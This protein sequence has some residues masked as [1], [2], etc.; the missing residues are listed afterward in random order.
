MV[1]KHINQSGTGQTHVHYAAC[2]RVVPQPHTARRQRLLVK[3]G[4]AEM[5][6]VAFQCRHSYH[7]GWQSD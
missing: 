3:T 6:C 4:Q 1:Q 2:S 5:P 7:D